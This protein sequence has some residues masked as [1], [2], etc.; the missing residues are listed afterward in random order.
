[1]FLTWGPLMIGG[2]YL[3][4]T[5]TV[6]GWVLVSSL[7]YSLLVTTVLFGKHIDKI[8]AGH[9]ARNSH[10]AGDPGRAPR[11]A[12]RPGADDRL[13]PALIVLAALVGWVG[14]C[15]LLVVLA[16]PLLLKVLAQFSRPAPESPPHS[17]V[18]WPLWFVGGAFT[19]SA[20]RRRPPD[21]GPLPQRRAARD[22]AALDHIASMLGTDVPDR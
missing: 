16:I 19:H 20:S 6:P 7:P 2:T 12:R 13:L 21:P 14:P 15:V 5:G 8:V 3:V 17:Y 1:M 10:A 11:A 9:R 22:P 4:A 18:G